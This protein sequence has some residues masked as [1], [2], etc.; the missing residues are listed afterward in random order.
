MSYDKPNRIPYVFPSVDW[1]AAQN[2]KI[3][4][5]GPKGK[6]GKIFDVG[7]LNT[8]EAFNGGTTTPK[9]QVGTTTD[10]DAY[11]KDFDLQGL[12]INDAK[13]V[14]STWDPGTPKDKQSFDA[15]MVDP[16][17]PADELVVFTAVVGT[18]SETGQGLPFIVIDW[19]D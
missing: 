7:V 1:G 2:S 11:V 14:R 17:L 9:I 3:Y 15:V 4:I 16:N 8:S 18:G 5:R 10:A 12:G 13:T 19:D 6:K